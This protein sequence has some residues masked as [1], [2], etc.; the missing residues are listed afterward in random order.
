MNEYQ[1]S[2]LEE[3]VKTNEYFKGYRVV[4][5]Y[6]ILLASSLA[7]DRVDEL[8][9]E[10]KTHLLGIPVIDVTL[11]GESSPLMV[12]TQRTATSLVKCFA[13]EQRK[14]LYPELS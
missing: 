8:N 6:A 13:G 10:I 2:L 9:K 3:L 12:A 7:G 5:D 14:L 11:D 4:I 1:R